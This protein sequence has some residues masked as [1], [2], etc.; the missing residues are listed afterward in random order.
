MFPFAFIFTGGIVHS[1][2]GR[3]WSQTPKL[4]WARMRVYVYIYIYTGYIITNALPRSKFSSKLVPMGLETN[5]QQRPYIIGMVGANILSLKTLRGLIPSRR[6]SNDRR[7]PP[8]Q[9]GAKQPLTFQ[10]L[11]YD[12]FFFVFQLPRV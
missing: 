2:V 10:S 3:I 4:S 5:Q 6:L 9:R 7:A 12:F 1:L 8:F 11:R